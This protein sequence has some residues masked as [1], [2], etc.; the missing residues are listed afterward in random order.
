MNDFSG[1]TGMPVVEPRFIR[2]Y[3]EGLRLKPRPVKVVVRIPA[4][5]MAGRYVV[6]GAGQVR[7][8]PRARAAAQETP[9]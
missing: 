8:A 1:G 6:P 4:A 9:V 7:V 2:P 5:A 3:H